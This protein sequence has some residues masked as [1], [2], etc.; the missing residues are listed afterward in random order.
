SAARSIPPRFAHTG[1]TPPRDPHIVRFRAT[2]LHSCARLH[3]RAPDRADPTIRA[4]QISMKHNQERTNT[5]TMSEIQQ[6]IISHLKSDR[7]RPQR[8]RG[9]AQELNLAGEE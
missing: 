4:A 2:P 3:A 7:Y 5:P 1:L 6:K 8:P 9:L